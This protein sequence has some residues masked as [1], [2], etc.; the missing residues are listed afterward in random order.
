MN[1]GSDEPHFGEV[2]SWADSPPMM[3]IAVNEPTR[4]QFIT[5]IYMHGGISRLLWHGSLPGIREQW[6]RLDTEELG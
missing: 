5:C 3:V 1:T 4:P 2:W 6:K